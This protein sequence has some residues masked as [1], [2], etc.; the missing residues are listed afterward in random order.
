MTWL[1]W[2]TVIA[3]YWVAM[4]LDAAL[5]SR[6][7]AAPSFL[8]VLAGSLACLSRPAAG[9]VAG[10]FAGMLYGAVAGANLAIYAIV[11]TTI[12]FGTS[13]AAEL[14]VE[15]GPREMA[16]IVGA[17]TVVER[18][19]LLVLLSP[20]DAMD[21]FR[22]AAFMVLLNALL[23]FPVYALLRRLFPSEEQ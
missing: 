23:T 5:L 3:L 10:F 20:P 17:A 21:F 14:P 11:R 13:W 4:G 16:I 2:L 6:L 8:M 18:L 19:A 15:R 1:R 12:G 22:R 9:S 7:W